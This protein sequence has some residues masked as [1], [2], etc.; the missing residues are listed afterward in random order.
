MMPSNRQFN[1]KSR[2]KA[3]LESGGIA[4]TLD[5]NNLK[6]ETN[7]R[8]NSKKDLSYKGEIIE[9]INESFENIS[10]A[11]ILEHGPS[12][13]D[14]F[15]Y[16]S[17]L[18]RSWKDIDTGKIYTNKNPKFILNYE[19]FEESVRSYRSSS[20]RRSKS[21]INENNVANCSEKKINLNGPYSN[22]TQINLFSA[23]L[24]SANGTQRA[25][26]SFDCYDAKEGI[27][28]NYIFFI[29]F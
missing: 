20:D 11:S 26:A 3:V 7:N 12:N 21:T 29:Y 6:N 18:E 14:E 13:S 5:H 17:G 2:F 27:Y 16:Y 19:E 28:L 22:F 15:K 23:N 4:S 10:K 9:N 24:L 25:I 8:T 1:L